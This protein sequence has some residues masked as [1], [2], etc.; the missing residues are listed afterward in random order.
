MMKSRAT[1]KVSRAVLIA[2]VLV[3]C[4]VNGTPDKSGSAGAFS[5]YEAVVNFHNSMMNYESA[6]I[7]LFY[8]QPRSCE[9]E[10]GWWN[11]TCI[12]ECKQTR[13]TTLAQEQL[14][15]FAA[16]L[17]T[18]APETPDQCAQARA[19]RDGCEAQ[20]DPSQYPTLEEALAVWAQRS[21]CMEASKVHFCE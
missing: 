8:N 5:C 16:S 15:L 17:L 21:A 1:S 2:A 7:S 3:V 11:L 20:Y 14:G 19:M 4:L 10:C 12:D 18:C 13:Q 6:R 9:D